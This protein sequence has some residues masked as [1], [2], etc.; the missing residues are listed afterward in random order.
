M[1]DEESL[2]VGASK[3]DREAFDDLLET[4][5]PRVRKLLF[6]LGGFSGEIED[7]TQEVFLRMIDGL[8]RLRDPGQGKNWLFGIAVNVTREAAR[9]RSQSPQ[10][11][12]P[13]IVSSPG[14]V[15]GDASANEFASRTREAIRDLGASLREVI[16]LSVFEGLKAQEIAAVLDL[17]SEAVRHRLFR[18]RRILEKR[19]LGSSSIPMSPRTSEDLQ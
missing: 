14:D 16:V 18:A 8:P 2:W 6:R 17:T 9:R 3:G 1:R 7:L 13:E 11:G 15:D 12:L 10:V 4:L 5:L 19:L